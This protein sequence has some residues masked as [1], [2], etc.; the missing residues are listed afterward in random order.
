MRAGKAN[1]RARVS[2]DE[3]EEVVAPSCFETHRSAETV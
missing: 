3:N 1:V 2:K